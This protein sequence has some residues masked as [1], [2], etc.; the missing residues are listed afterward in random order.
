VHFIT[1]ASASVCFSCFD[2]KHSAVHSLSVHAT[3]K[4]QWCYV[5]LDMVISGMLVRASAHTSIVEVALNT[6]RILPIECSLCAAVTR[7]L[8]ACVS[9][10]LRDHPVSKAVLVY[11]RNLERAHI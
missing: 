7:C 11:A 9:I 2:T 10:S 8:A 4:L 3:V 6:H 5:L 1:L